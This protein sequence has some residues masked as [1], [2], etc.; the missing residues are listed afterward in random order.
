MKKLLAVDGNSIINRAFYGIRPL[1][2]RDG[3]PT[4]AIYGTVNIINRQLTALS[5]DYVAVCFDVHA[6]T[7]RHKLFAEYKAGR[8]PTCSRSSTPAKPC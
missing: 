8:R 5:P 7:F 2:T 6:P 3:R 1:S 4:N